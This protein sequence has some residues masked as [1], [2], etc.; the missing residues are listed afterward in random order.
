M[1]SSS[2]RLR[3]WRVWQRPDGGRYLT[4]G[5]RTAPPEDETLVNTFLAANWMSAEKEA[6]GQAPEMD[7]GI[8]PVVEAVS[9][10]PG[11][12]T[13]A[14][15]EGH[16]DRGDDCAVVTLCFED[17]LAM[18]AFLVALDMTAKQISPL[19]WELRLDEAR[20]QELP[21]Q[22][23]AFEWMIFEE[24]GVPGAERLRGLA[25]TLLAVSGIADVTVLP[26]QHLGTLP[27]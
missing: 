27:N 9:F 15:C 4:F 16:P 24:Q 2:P 1:N 13:M 20:T 12:M 8:E 3:R 21:E 11:V 19:R 17:T 22:A 26:I 25:Q 5:E 23:L 6:F 7:A 14:A 10:F 18:R